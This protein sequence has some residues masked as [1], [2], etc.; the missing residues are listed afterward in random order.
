MRGHGGPLAGV[1]RQRV[2]GPAAH[3][4]DR[5]AQRAGGAPGRRQRPGRPRG[6]SRSASTAA[7]SASS[8]RVVRSPGTAPGVLHLQQLDGPLDVGEPAAAQLEVRRRVGPA[9]QPL[10]VDAGLDPPHLAHVVLADPPGGE[11]QRVDQLGEPAAQVRVADHRARPAAAPAPPRPPTTARSSARRSPGCAPA[12]PAC[13]RGAGRRRPRGPGRCP[14]ATAAGATRGPRR[15][16]ARL[17]SSPVGA[18]AA[19]RARTSR[20]RRCRS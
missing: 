13:P 12:G 11:A 15:W 9:R 14:A 6:P 19:G 8:V 17:P 2:R 10:V 5:V 18:L 3:L 20:R 7:S 1:A 16:A 4:G